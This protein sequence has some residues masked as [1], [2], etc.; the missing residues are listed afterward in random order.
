[1]SD[2]GGSHEYRE[3]DPTKSDS[4]NARV[5]IAKEPAVEPYT[6]TSGLPGSGQGHKARRFW[7][8][9]R[10]PAALCAAVLLGLSGLFLYDIA[11]VRADRKAMQWRISL[12]HQL[13][14]RHLDDVWI[15]LGASVAA[16]LGLWLLVLALTPGERQ[17]LPMARSGTAG[18]RAGLDRR[19]AELVLR[20]RAMEVSGVRWA[21]VDVG[22]RKIKARATSHFR[23]LEEVRGD[24]TAALGEAVRQLGLARSPQLSIRL[25]R[26]EKKG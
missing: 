11:S 8:G 14:T 17:V 25:H 15:I 9:R 3:Q 10:V 2:E 4:E 12:A 1:M 6:A 16:A 18:V 7:S 23:E 20:D 21:K 22:R 26:A 19:A 13:A 5:S 24:L